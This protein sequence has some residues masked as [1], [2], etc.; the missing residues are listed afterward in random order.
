MGNKEYENQLGKNINYSNFKEN[1][2]EVSGPN[3][4]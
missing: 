2:L 1:T 4:G 3:M